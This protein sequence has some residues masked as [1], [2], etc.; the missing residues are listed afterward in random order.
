MR[1]ANHEIRCSEKEKGAVSLNSGLDLGY[2]STGFSERKYPGS[3]R[4]GDRVRR[5]RVLDASPSL[6]LCSTSIADI[7]G[8]TLCLVNLRYSVAIVQRFLITRNGRI[9][10]QVVGLHSSSRRAAYTTPARPLSTPP[11]PAS[12]LRQQS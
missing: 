9:P 3:L 6:L 2:V 10:S 7:D 12:L 11:K 8:A 1:R 4:P 5:P